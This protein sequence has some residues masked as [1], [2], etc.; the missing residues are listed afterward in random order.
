[1][2]RSI[3]LS[4]FFDHKKLVLQKYIYHD[5]KIREQTELFLLRVYKNQS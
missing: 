1:M 4:L 3:F 2:Y 5:P